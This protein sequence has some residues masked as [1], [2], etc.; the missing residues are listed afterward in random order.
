MR[1]FITFR[2][3]DNDFMSGSRHAME[4]MYNEFNKELHNDNL[5]DLKVMFIRLMI[6][7]QMAKHWSW[8]GR[9]REED[10]FDEVKRY[11]KYFE[12]S[13]INDSK[14]DTLNQHNA[15]WCSIDLNTGYIW[16]H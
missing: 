5:D 7:Y 4:T 9:Y 1:N 11:L 15:E 2:F 14:E 3:H 6:G 16:N 12:N 10:Y 8:G 13:S